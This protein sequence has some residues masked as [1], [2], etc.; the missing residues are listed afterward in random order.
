MTLRLHP[1]LPSDIAT[2][3]N[4]FQKDSFAQSHFAKRRTGIRRSIVP[5][6][7]V[8]EHQSTPITSPLL[9]LPKGL[10]KDAVTCFRVIQHVIGERSRPVEG[11]TVAARYTEGGMTRSSSAFSI[12]T[13]GLAKKGDGSERKAYTGKKGVNG[14]NDGE[15]DGALSGK[16]IGLEEIR[17]LTLLAVTHLEMRDEA[18]AQLIK[19]LTQN[20]DQSVLLSAFSISGSSYDLAS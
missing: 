9:I 1:L 16:S 2:D 3:I 5:M 7:Q 12:L 18:Y 20:P 15:S 6:A 11:A 13:L 4:S 10:H 19:Q 17:W 14:A 8:L